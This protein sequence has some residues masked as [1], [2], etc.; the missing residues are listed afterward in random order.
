MCDDASIYRERLDEI[1]KKEKKFRTRSRVA[2]NRVRDGREDLGVTTRGEGETR[3]ELP[4]VRIQFPIH[5]PIGSMR[6]SHTR[7]FCVGRGVNIVNTLFCITLTILVSE[8]RRGRYPYR[9]SVKSVLE[10]VYYVTMAQSVNNDDDFMRI[11]YEF[12]KNFTQ[13]FV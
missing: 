11:K 5:M 12:E 6:S 8:Y 13:M 9:W 10:C 3:C 4:F 1:K 2:R 7:S